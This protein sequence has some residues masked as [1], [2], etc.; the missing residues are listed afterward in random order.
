LGIARFMARNFC[1]HANILSLEDTIL[2]PETNPPPKGIFPRSLTENQD[3]SPSPNSEEECSSSYSLSLLEN[4]GCQDRPLSPLDLTPSPP[5]FDSKTGDDASHSLPISMDK[6]STQHSST[7]H[8]SHSSLEPPVANGKDPMSPTFSDGP[9]VARSP[10]SARFSRLRTHKEDGLDAS[11][12]PQQSWID[13]PA[14]SSLDSEIPNHATVSPTTL[15]AFRSPPTSS[16]FRVSLPESNDCPTSDISLSPL[17]RGLLAPPAP[18][19]SPASNRRQ[20]IPLGIFLSGL[21][22][23]VPSAAIARH[24]EMYNYPHV[25]VVYEPH[26]G[27]AQFILSPSAMTKIIT[28]L[29]AL[30]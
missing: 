11:R 6:F 15:P 4:A 23:F 24:V 30:D 2:H 7:A 27:H 25:S 22:P 17:L 16:T 18:P 28:L 8:S 5:P 9:S 14:H 12:T 29:R 1:W 26:L 19:V 21:D 3:A 10:Q 13:V 20:V